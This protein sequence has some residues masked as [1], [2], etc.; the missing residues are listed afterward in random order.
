MLRVPGLLRAEAGVV[1]VLAA[2]RVVG[3]QPVDSRVPA[4]VLLG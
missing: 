1:V 2:V 4:G 3:L